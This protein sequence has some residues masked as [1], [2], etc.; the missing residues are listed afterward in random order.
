[1]RT[2]LGNPPNLLS[3]YYARGTAREPSFAIFQPLSNLHPLGFLLPAMSETGSSNGLKIGAGSL[4]STING[5]FSLE[6]I[7]GDNHDEVQHLASRVAPTT[8]W[9]EENIERPLA[10]GYC[11]ECEGNFYQ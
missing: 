2:A 9:D 5:A 10:E 1:M 4:D 7:L 11:V 8:G 3:N 6:N